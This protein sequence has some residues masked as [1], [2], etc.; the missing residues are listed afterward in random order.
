MIKRFSIFAFLFFTFSCQNPVKNKKV[1]YSIKKELL[2]AEDGMNT[3]SVKTKN[4][5]YILIE[6]GPVSVIQRG[7]DVEGHIFE[8]F[9]KD[10]KRVIDFE[11]EGI[12]TKTPEVKWIKKDTICIITW[13]SGPFAHEIYVPFKTS[14]PYRFQA[15]ELTPDRTGIVTIEEEFG[16]NKIG[17]KDSFRVQMKQIRCDDSIYV[18]IHLFKRFMQKWKLIQKQ[19]LEKD[20]ITSLFAKTSDFNNDGHFDLTFQTSTAARGANEI[21]TLFIFDTIKEQLKCI[22]NSSDYPNLM[23]NPSLNCI[24]A[25]LVYAGTSTVFLKLESDSLREFAVVSLFD[26]RVN[27]STI[28]KKGIEKYLVKDKIYKT[29]KGEIDNWARFITYQPLKERRF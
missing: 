14:N 28:N 8:I 3:Y 5:S 19:T 20:G 10:N 26:G 24:D 6:G 16:T 21:R 17:L 12:D 13:F 29:K 4:D 11:K 1:D 23:Y 18:E 22:R 9:Y 7:N 27:V 25:F 15:N 2:F